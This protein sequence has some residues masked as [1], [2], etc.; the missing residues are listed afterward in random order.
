MKIIDFEPKKNLCILYGQV[1]VMMYLFVISAFHIDLQDVPF[2]QLLLFIR[3]FDSFLS[4][5]DTSFKVLASFNW[6][7]NLIL[8]L[9]IRWSS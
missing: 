5:S 8:S 4:L 6:F 9:M 2:S 7:A 1:F 3:S